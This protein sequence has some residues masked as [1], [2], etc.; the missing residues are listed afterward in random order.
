MARTG[1]RCVTRAWYGV[2]ACA[3]SCAAEGDR[4]EARIGNWRDYQGDGRAKKQ[5]S[6]AT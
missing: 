4:R 6:N 2:G 5:A 1:R 3:V